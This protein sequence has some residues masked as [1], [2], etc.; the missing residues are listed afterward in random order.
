MTRTHSDQVKLP[1]QSPAARREKTFRI[2][3][4]KTQGDEYSQK[5]GVKEGQDDLHLIVSRKLAN[6]IKFNG[7]IILVVMHAAEATGICGAMMFWNEDMYT[8]YIVER[9][10][11]QVCRMPLGMKLMHPSLVKVPAV[12]QRLIRG[13]KSGQIQFERVP[14]KELGQAQSDAMET[15]RLRN[16]TEKVGNPSQYRGKR[17]DARKVSTIGLRAKGPIRSREL[18]V[19]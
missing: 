18:T 3:K 7:A 4:L 17:R 14:R 2:R 5:A 16:E 13:W 11:V 19:D 8:K 10:G 12:V 1:K 9:Y 6:H 15:G